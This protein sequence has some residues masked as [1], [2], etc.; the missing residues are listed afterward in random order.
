LFVYNER[1]LF[2]YNERYLF[3]YNERYLFVYWLS[4]ELYFYLKL[5][6]IMKYWNIFW[7]LCEISNFANFPPWLYN[8]DPYWPKYHSLYSRWNH[9]V[10]HL[11]IPFKTPFYIEWAPP[12]IEECCFS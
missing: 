1:Y 9:R 4:L 8:L 11:V 12:C 10:G 3:V 6:F 5:T 7:V 2:V